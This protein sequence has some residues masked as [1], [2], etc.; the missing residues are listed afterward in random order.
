[1]MYSV[2]VCVCGVFNEHCL[3]VKM[4]R[5]FGVRVCACVCACVYVYMFVRL[6]VCAHV[7][8]CAYHLLITALNAEECVFV[9]K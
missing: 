8:A 4:H 2:W 7:C 3:H 1:M 9:C 5:V 6:Y